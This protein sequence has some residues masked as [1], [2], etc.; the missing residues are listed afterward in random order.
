MKLLVRNLA[1]ATTE[2]KLLT[3]F[4]EHGSIQSCNLVLDKETGASKGF[5]FIE[6]PKVG[7][8]KAAIKQLNGYKL[9]GNLIRVKKAEVKKGEEQ[10]DAA[11]A[12]VK[13]TPKAEKKQTIAKPESASEM[14]DTK[15]VW[16]SVKD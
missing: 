10:V 7:E 1:K 16:G 11:T 13:A 3:L 5:A 6:M 4:K 12:E 2:E 9:A 8:A 14:V 15:D